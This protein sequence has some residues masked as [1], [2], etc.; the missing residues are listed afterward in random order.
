MEVL[1]QIKLMD[2]SKYFNRRE[3]LMIKKVEP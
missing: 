2:W 3:T 1:D